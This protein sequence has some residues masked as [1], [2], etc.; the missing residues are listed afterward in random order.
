MQ[1]HW[2]AS[3]YAFFK[4]DPLIEYVKGRRVHAFQCAN[5]GCKHIVHRYLGGKDMA[6]TVN[7]RKHVRSCWG[8]EALDRAD[9]S[10]SALNARE[11]VRTYRRTGDIKV[12]FGNIGKKT[13]TFSTHQHTPSETRYDSLTCHGCT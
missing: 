8:K 7:M 2:T 6:S 4:P 3:V 13:V 11:A 5:T 1:K 10:G 9:A 12:A